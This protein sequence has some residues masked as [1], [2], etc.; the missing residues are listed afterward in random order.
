MTTQP[1]A[2]IRISELRDRL[3]VVDPRLGNLWSQELNAD[4]L[5]AD[6]MAKSDGAKPEVIWPTVHSL[7]ELLNEHDDDLDYLAGKIDHHVRNQSKDEG[8]AAAKDFQKLKAA[9]DGEANNQGPKH[10]AARGKARSLIAESH[11]RSRIKFDSQRKTQRGLWVISGILMV[12][13]IIAAVAQSQIEAAFVSPPS[14]AQQVVVT[15]AWFFAILLF[16]GALGGLFSALY[17]LYLTKDVE[18]TS[19]C[20]PRPS[21]VATKVA[22]GCWASI[23]AG[24]AVQTG[25]IVG[26]FTSLPAAILI[27]ISFGYAQQA[28]TGI[29]DKQTSGLVSK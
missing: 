18:D 10:A 1:R 15:N 2:I 23:I 6:G 16:A 9:A 27:G 12:G 19:W 3:K 11:E 5:T 20:D 4:L 28:I 25:A 26:G 29:L 8:D 14:S 17:S 22:V 24:I 7:E 13:A 21:L